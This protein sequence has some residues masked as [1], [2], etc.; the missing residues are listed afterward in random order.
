M[1]YPCKLN[2]A[3]A[4]HQHW[5][6]SQSIFGLRAAPVLVFFQRTSITSVV[7]AQAGTQSAQVFENTMDWI[8]AFAGMTNFFGP[9][10]FS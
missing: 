1:I 10:K 8:P 9:W 6:H 7:P 5:R 2:N 4:K 3:L